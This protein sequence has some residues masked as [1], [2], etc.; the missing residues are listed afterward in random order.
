VN[1]TTMTWTKLHTTETGIRLDVLRSTSPSSFAS[2]DCV[3]SDDADTTAND[4]TNPSSGQVFY[5][6]IRAEASC[7]GGTLGYQTNG[8]ERSGVSCG[9]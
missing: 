8:T 6:L 4:A 1:K 3:E 7:G 2:A 9:L 5:Y